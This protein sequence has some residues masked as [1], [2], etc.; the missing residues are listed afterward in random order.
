MQN[1][2]SVGTDKIRTILF[3][4]INGTILLVAP[5]FFFTI[6]L[7]YIYLLRA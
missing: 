2:S 4:A 7:V 5:L 6:V 3:K 1:A